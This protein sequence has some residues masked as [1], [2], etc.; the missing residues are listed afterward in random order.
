MNR[1]GLSA[2][3]VCFAALGGSGSRLRPPPSISLAEA[4]VIVD[5]AI[6]FARARNVFR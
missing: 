2:G 5:A 3:A 4:R 6:A 1:V